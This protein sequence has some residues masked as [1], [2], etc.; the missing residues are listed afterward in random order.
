MGAKISGI[1]K[2]YAYDRRGLFISVAHPIACY[3]YDRSRDHSFGLAAM[4][5]SDIVIKN[6]GIQLLVSFR[7]NFNN[8]NTNEF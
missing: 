6:A 5:Q 1:R 3:R 2:Q 7:K 8:W 4:T